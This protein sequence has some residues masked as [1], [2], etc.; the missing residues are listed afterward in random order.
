MLPT[1]APAM[2]YAFSAILTALALPLSLY[3]THA[4]LAGERMKIVREERAVTGEYRFVT[5]QR[6]LFEDGVE[7]DAMNP[8]TG[9]ETFL[10]VY[11]N[12]QEIHREEGWRWYPTQNLPAPGTDVTG[13][14]LPDVVFEDWSGGA[15]CC[16][17]YFI[18]EL[19][20]PLHVIKVETGDS[21]AGFANLDGAPGFEIYY[22]D[23]SFTDWTNG[24]AGSPAPSVVLR[25]N[26]GSYV[27]APDLMRQSAMNDADLRREAEKVRQGEWLY[28]IG[29]LPVEFLRIAV[30]LIYTGNVM[31]ALEFIQLA[32]PEIKPGQSAFI[33]ELFTCQLRR[34]AFWRAIAQMNGLSPDEW[35]MEC[36]TGDIHYPWP[37]IVPAPSGPF[38]PGWRKPY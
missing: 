36:Y 37:W 34:S 35:P 8:P 29:Y 33:E 22:A 16:F 21:Q 6:V 26:D 5:E 11:K 4:A 17:S 23:F 14:G 32:W 12:G 1:W 13:D 19:K 15:H 7:Y 27:P 31:Q 9:F 18:F 30:G 38:E 3:M 10:I 20:E 24:F 2:R 25:Y 28:D